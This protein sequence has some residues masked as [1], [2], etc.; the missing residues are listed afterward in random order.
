MDL[1]RKPE[2]VGVAVEFTLTELHVI[3][4]LDEGLGETREV[5]L[6][7]ALSFGIQQREYTMEGKR[8]EIK[9]ERE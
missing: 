5:D 7:V 4:G 3:E 9:R 2:R 8:G 1:G 6:D